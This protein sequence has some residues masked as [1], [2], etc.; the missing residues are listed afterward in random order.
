MD[1]SIVDGVRLQGWS[2]LATLFIS[3]VWAFALRDAISA[4]RNFLRNYDGKKRLFLW[5]CFF[6][7]NQFRILGNKQ[8]QSFETLRD[9]FGTQVQSIGRMVCM[10]DKITGSEY[11]RRLW[12]LFEVAMC[13][14]HHIPMEVMIPEKSQKEVETLLAEGFHAVNDAI[15]IDSESAKATM[16]EDQE[17]IKKL[18]ETQTSYTEVNRS[19]RKALRR[20]I[21]NEIARALD[22]D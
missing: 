3:W 4:L 12:C 7:N 18:I 10:M 6:Q 15:V 1:C 13:V 2:A 19:V 11:S 20:G 22:S 14:E 9:I 21:L 17:N 5:W 16:I 8:K